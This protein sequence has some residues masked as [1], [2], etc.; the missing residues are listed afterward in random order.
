MTVRTLILETQGQLESYLPQG[1][2]RMYIH[3]GK[4]EYVSV[5]ICV[6]L[7]A[8]RV[9]D[10]INKFMYLWIFIWSHMHLYLHEFVCICYTCR[11]KLHKYIKDWLCFEINLLECTNCKYRIVAVKIRNSMCSVVSFLS[12]SI[13]FY[14]MEIFI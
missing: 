5:H 12:F 11:L 13:S 9:F 14:I 6:I 1:K 10:Y 2:W 3:M 8:T 4:F 7:Y